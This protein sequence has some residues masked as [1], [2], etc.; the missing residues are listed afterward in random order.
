MC[1]KKH[2]RSTEVPPPN[3][4][5]LT[6]VHVGCPTGWKIR[7][8]S[9]FVTF[10]FH[11]RAHLRAPQCGKHRQP[12]KANASYPWHAPVDGHDP[13]GEHVRRHPEAN[14]PLHIRPHIG[15][16]LPENAPGG[17]LCSSSQCLHTSRRAIEDREIEERNVKGL[18]DCYLDGNLP[19]W[20]LKREGSH[21][22]R[23]SNG[24][25]CMLRQTAI[26]K[27]KG[28]KDQCALLLQLLPAFQ[29]F[30]SQDICGHRLNRGHG[31]A[32]RDGPALTDGI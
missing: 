20:L 32:K 31:N 17:K 26:E 18:I 10:A 25:D 3:L 28:C 24:V 15:M 8:A 6:P 19:G 12:N 4:N 9:S 21:K 27:S 13:K 16:P 29:E 14:A 22:A 23:I 5:A 1:R 2:G 11:L 30:L 7:K